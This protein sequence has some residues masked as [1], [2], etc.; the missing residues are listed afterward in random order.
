M[1]AAAALF[2]CA[3][4]ARLAT[5]LCGL[6]RAARHRQ[7]AHRKERAIRASTGCM[8]PTTGEGSD[9]RRAKGRKCSRYLRSVVLIGG[10][11]VICSGRRRASRDRYSRLQQLNDVGQRVRW[12]E[13]NDH[14]R[15][16]ELPPH[17]HGHGSVRGSPPS[18]TGK[19]EEARVEVCRLGRKA[20]LDVGSKHKNGNPH[21][22]PR[23]ERGC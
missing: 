18:G 20:R 19:R 17:S 11:T 21:S 7:H 9:G 14:A 2:D 1:S 12:D 16:W 10:R 3:G 4:G 22:A 8:S 13:R 6:E 5:A 15:E 23:P